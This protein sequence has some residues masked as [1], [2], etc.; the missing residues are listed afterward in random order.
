MCIVLAAGGRG[1][2]L[3]P[4]EGE[5]PLPGDPCPWD[6]K[7]K[8]LCISVARP[9]VLCGDDDG[10]ANYG[11]GGAR[12]GIICLIS[13]AEKIQQRCC[14]AV[15]SAIYHHSPKQEVQAVTEVFTCTE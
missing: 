4:P 10:D 2:I 12:M 14:C 8:K 15:S 6:G 11:A 7:P 3:G 1:R 9:A 13:E 5:K